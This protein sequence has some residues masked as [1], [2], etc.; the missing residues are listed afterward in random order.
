MGGGGGEESRREGEVANRLVGRTGVWM[1]WN[2]VSGGGVDI[3]M[4]GMY[5]NSGKNMKTETGN[6]TK[7]RII[8]GTCLSYPS[9]F[10]TSRPQVHFFVYYPFI[11][12]LPLSFPPFPFLFSRF[13]PNRTVGLVCYSCFE[14]K[15]KWGFLSLLDVFFWGGGRLGVRIG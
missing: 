4:E 11:I 3:M 12:P 13:L 5:I 10:R 6:N 9:L 14:G 1:N 7:S 15:E 2:G 8:P